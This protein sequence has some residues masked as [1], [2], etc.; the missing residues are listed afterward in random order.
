MI[1]P[2]KYFSILLILLAAACKPDDSDDAIPF[3]P[4]APIQI[5]ITLPTYN[6]LQ[7]F[8]G[9]IYLNSGGVKGLIVYHHP[10]GYYAFERNC[11]FQPN[12]ACSTVDVEPSG[13]RM[14]DTC[15]GSYFDFEGQPAGGPAWR[16]LRKYRTEILGTRLTITDE[17]IDE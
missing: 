12:D 17:I 13:V 8:G 14:S 11:S 6:R 10:G 1:M 7:A 9:Y 5:D 15:C 3:V 16:P 2:R 4:F